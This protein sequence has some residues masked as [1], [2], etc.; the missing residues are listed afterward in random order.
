VHGADASAQSAQPEFF[1]EQDLRFLQAVS[2]WVGSVV[3]SAE[4]AERTEAAILEKG[5]RM[6]ADELVTVLAHDLRNYLTPIR[7]R[8]QLLTLVVCA[9]KIDRNEDFR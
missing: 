8:V 2:R 7:A 3:H 6:A 4:L 5:R 9:V 1:A